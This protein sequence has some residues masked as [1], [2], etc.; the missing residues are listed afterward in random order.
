MKQATKQVWEIAVNAM[1]PLS[2]V[3]AGTLIA[4]QIAIAGL[5]KD[6]Q[7]YQDRLE[8][9]EDTQRQISRELSAMSRDIAV[10]R[11]I[12]EERTNRGPTD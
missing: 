9:V 3:L 4:H 6:V 12:L 8:N 5:E 7:R 10:I 1:V 11:Q 2:M